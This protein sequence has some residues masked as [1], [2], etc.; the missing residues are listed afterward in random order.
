MESSEH[1]LDTIRQSRNNLSFDWECVLLKAD[2]SQ[3]S[4][5][6]KLIAFSKDGSIR[7]KDWFLPQGFTRSTRPTHKCITNSVYNGQW[8]SLTMDGLGVY[9]FPHSKMYLDL[10]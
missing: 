10:E 5:K 1:S 7:H 8:N 3:S 6:T 4:F 9:T 2:T